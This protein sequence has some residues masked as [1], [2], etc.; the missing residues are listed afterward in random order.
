MFDVQQMYINITT[1]M[2]KYTS[3]IILILI[4]INHTFCFILL[5]H[6][7][8]ISNQLLPLSSSIAEVHTYLTPLDIQKQYKDIDFIE[9]LISKQCIQPRSKLDLLSS[10][11]IEWISTVVEERAQARARGDYLFADQIRMYLESICSTSSDTPLTYFNTSLVSLGL[12]HNKW[13]TGY[14]LAINDVPR[15]LGGGSSWE[16]VPMSN[17]SLSEKEENEEEEDNM[18]ESKKHSVLSFAHQA[19]GLAVTASRRNECCN[20]EELQSIVQRAKVCI[21]P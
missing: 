1:R 21:Y 8:E 11:D 7:R 2:T 19:L 6:Q 15:R 14:Q 20:R 18:D 4:W 10:L 16:I 9:T 12:L 17:H 3:L 13:P 5:N